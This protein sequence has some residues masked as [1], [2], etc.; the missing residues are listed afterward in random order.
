MKGVQTCVVLN[1]RIIS[2]VGLGLS[3]GRATA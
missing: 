1:D 3:P 2:R